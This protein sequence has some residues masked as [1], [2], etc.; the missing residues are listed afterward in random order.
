M[1]PWEESST[2]SA[3]CGLKFKVSLITEPQKFHSV[4]ALKCNLNE[5][6]LIHGRVTTMISKFSPQIF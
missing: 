4:G 2:F 3:L 6:N 5:K 1:V